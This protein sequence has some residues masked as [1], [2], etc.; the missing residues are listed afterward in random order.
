[1]EEEPR[2]REALR[3]EGGVFLATPGHMGFCR[4]RAGHSDP[5]LI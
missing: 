5:R 3:A 4:R 1:M 2:C